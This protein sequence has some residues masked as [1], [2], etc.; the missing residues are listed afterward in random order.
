[1]WPAN[2]RTRYSMP[3]S[4]LARSRVGSPPPRFQFLAVAMD[5]NTTDMV[6]VLPLRFAFLLILTASR[7]SDPRLHH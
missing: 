3:L 4:E 6:H 1:M 5:E 7:A 2:R